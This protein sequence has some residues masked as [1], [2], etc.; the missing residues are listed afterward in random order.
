MRLVA[1]LLVA[2]ALIYSCWYYPAVW[3]SVAACF[4]PALLIAIVH[5]ERINIFSGGKLGVMTATKGNSLAL[6][7]AF[8][9]PGRVT[10]I[11]KP[12]YFYKSKKLPISVGISV[13]VVERIFDVIAVIGLA[14]IAL[15]FISL[16]SQNFSAT[17]TG[18]II[19]VSIILV[20]VIVVAIRFPDAIERSLKFLPFEALRNFITASFHS[21]REGLSYGFRYWSIILTI[22]VW[23][24]S[25]GLYWL[26]LQF[27]GGIKLGLDQS[28]IV[29]LIGTLGITITITPGGLGTFEA[30]VTL[31]LQQYGYPF[32]AALASAIGLRVVAFLPNAFIAG[33][34][35]LF[36][37]FDFVKARRQ[38][39][40]L[41]AD[42]EGP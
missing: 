31:I 42:N 14:L 12:L 28:V 23:A 8:I 15:R 22:L 1:V 25:V 19:L 27:D 18:L 16:P 20:L 21:F 10:E 26:F 17:I 4:V 2:A 38:A 37:G 33:Y 30:A 7:G 41:E 9:I 24:G 39:E 13:L 34:V 29:F 36:E 3:I 6:V 32:E 40:A 11:L 5:G 35:V